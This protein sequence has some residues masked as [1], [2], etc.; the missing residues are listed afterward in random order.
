MGMP[1]LAD[2]VN[3]ENYYYVR[4]LLQGNGVRGHMGVLSVYG[5]FRG[6]ESGY[7]REM[8]RSA[9]MAR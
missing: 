7:A 8:S 2:L 1:R 5:M 4:G 6:V 3:R 9:A